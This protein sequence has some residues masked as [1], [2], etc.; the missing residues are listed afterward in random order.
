MFSWF[1]IVTKY[2]QVDE[3]KEN[4]AG[5]IRINVIFGRIRETIVAVE[6]Q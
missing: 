4:K 2:Y 5:N 6:N 1:L 3:M